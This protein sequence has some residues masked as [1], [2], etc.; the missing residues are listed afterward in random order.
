[1]AESLQS[2]MEE[3]R[4]FS[5]ARETLNVTLTDEM[6]ARREALSAILS[7]NGMELRDDSRLAYGFIMN[8]GDVHMI[9]HELLCTNF[10]YEHTNYDS[11]CQEGLRYIA[12]QLK[13][14]YD[15]PWRSVWSITREY[16]VPA[17]KVYALAESGYGMP[18]FD[19][20]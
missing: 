18:E 1:M 12:N 13:E 9:A 7:K 16:G 2:G 6:V 15:L 10:L 11:L 20:A 19:I 17:M 5:I 3:S 4:K 8:G 14:T